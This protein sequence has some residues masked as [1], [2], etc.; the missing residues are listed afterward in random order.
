[1]HVAE[2][3]PLPV[4]VDE[5]LVVIAL[6]RV[7]VTHRAHVAQQMKARDEAGAVFDDEAVAVEHAGDLLC[8]SE[9]ETDRQTAK[10]A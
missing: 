6:L 8:S 4:R 2:I 3:D 10:L 9:G 1:M 5:A 7:L